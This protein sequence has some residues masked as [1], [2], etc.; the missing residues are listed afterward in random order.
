MNASTLP[1]FSNIF[2]KFADTAQRHAQDTAI[3]SPEKG[4]AYI[5][6]TYAC[7]ETQVYQLGNFLKTQGI[8]PGDRVAILLEN[9]LDYPVAFLS[10]M[11]LNATAI[12]LDVQY[13]GP[14]I[15]HILKHAQATALITT[16]AFNAKLDTNIKHTIILNDDTI[17]QN[18]KDSPKDNHFDPA[19]LNDLAVLFYTS[20][21]THTPKGVMLTHHNLLS[22]V[23]SIQQLHLINSD[24]RIL[25]FLPLFH[26]FAFTVTLLTPLLSG[27]T[28][29]YAPGMASKE[30]L[31]CLRQTHITIF[32]GIP[33]VYGLFHHTIQEKLKALPLT[34]RI[35]LNP[36]K[37]FNHTLRRLTG[38]NLNKYLFKSIHTTFGSQ[39]RFMVSGGARLNPEINTHFTQWGFTLLEGYGLTETSPVAT[40]NTPQHQTIGSVGLAVPGVLVRIHEPNAEGIGEVV[41]RGP[42]I[43]KGYYQLPKETNDTLKEG[44]F[45]TGDLGYLDT[46]GFLFLTGRQKEEIV[47]STGKN[48]HPDEVEEHYLQSP[49]IKEICV[50]PDRSQNALTGLEQDALVAVVVADLDHFKAN[51]IATYRDKIKWELD[52]LSNQIPTHQRIRGF[53]ISQE[54]LPRTR[55]GKL[56]RYKIQEIYTLLHASTQFPSIKPTP[57]PSTSPAENS[58]PS[59]VQLLEFLSTRLKRP[60][61][62]SDHLE[63]DLGLDSLGKIEM[64]LDLQE[65]LGLTFDDDQTMSFYMCNTVDDIIKT[66]QDIQP[67]S[68]TT[69]NQDTVIDWKEILNTPLEKTIHHRI[70]LTLNNIERLFSLMIVLLLK[71]IF[72][73]L[74]WIR[75]QG[76]AQLPAQGPYILCP[77]HT[78]Y[79]DGLFILS[80]LPI[81]IVLQT[82]FVGTSI[83]F[84]SAILKPFIRI[85]RLIP[86]ELSYNLLEALKACAYVL[87]NKKI[88]CYFPEGQRSADGALGPFKKGIG[89]LVQELNVP[90]IPV[91]IKGAYHTW[92]RSQKYP[93]LAPIKIT[94]GKPF[95]SQELQD[96]TNTS[97]DTYETIASTLRTKLQDLI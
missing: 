63:L 13:D 85:A 67:E 15:A 66:F 81:S 17:Q 75:T 38:I 19:T 41:L 62:C 47:L 76:K 51:N 96:V 79:F 7:L 72:I 56:Q 26:A 78:S 22:N 90:V 64:L 92:G 46:K 52:T 36:L 31:S 91:Y 88:V 35:I 24:D 61:Q 37:K 14:Q 49:F 34:T 30:L 86:I 28:V 3:V 87:K 80:A 95:S 77:N 60:V 54:A 65:N 58:S 94:F 2:Q 16:Q 57:M 25:A 29:V 45:H 20:G 23:T 8:T 4:G 6:T 68:P 11:Y 21:T 10:L 39:L 59:V 50:L 42:N 84:E 18:L 53:A 1:K 69:L 9:G 40:F 33:Q 32:V 73:P 89:I 93:K 74:F 82:Y 43:M 71:I 83:F 97:Q 70:A 44:W 27:A 5:N 12:P 55:L 48:I